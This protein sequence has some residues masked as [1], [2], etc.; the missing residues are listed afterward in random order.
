M[1]GGFGSHVQRNLFPEM[2]NQ[3]LPKRF[4]T[5]VLENDDGGDSIHLGNIQ[6]LIWL[7]LINYSI[8]MLLII[9]ENL[10]YFNS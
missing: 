1:D 9:W 5:G 10:Y 7:L 6:S 8:A 3:L 4:D 2:M